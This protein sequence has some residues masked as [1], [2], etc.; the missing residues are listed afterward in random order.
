MNIKHTAA[1]AGTWLAG[2]AINL[3]AT[4]A[5][6]AGLDGATV[7]ANY[8]WPTLNEV[9]LPSGTAVVGAGIEFPDLGGWGV[10]VS[11]SVDVFDSGFSIS[12]PVGMLLAPPH[13]SITFDGLVLA[14]ALGALP[15]IT[16]VQLVFSNIPGFGAAQ[17]SFDAD[18]VYVNQIGF[19][20]FDAGATIEVAVNFAPVPEPASVLLMGL[21]VVALLAGRRLGARR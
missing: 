13:E 18:H 16:G 14:D 12:Y 1:A 2:L 19:T 10:G 17:L 11:P 4:G 6:H 8:H 5:A 15:S 9:L 20:S 3:A 21:G 7:T